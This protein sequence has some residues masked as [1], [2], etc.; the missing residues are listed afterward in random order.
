MTPA[1]DSFTYRS[2][3]KTTE[4]KDIKIA[5]HSLKASIKD[6]SGAVFNDIQKQGLKRSVQTHMKFY[7]SIFIFTV[8]TLIWLRNR[9]H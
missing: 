3:P 2:K 8:L 7:G 1:E 9:R 6:L 4:L 5:F